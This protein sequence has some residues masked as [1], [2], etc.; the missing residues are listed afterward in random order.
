MKPSIGYM[1][2]NKYLFLIEGILDLEDWQ[3]T[4]VTGTVQEEQPDTST[5]RYSHHSTYTEHQPSRYTVLYTQQSIGSFRL[6]LRGA[7]A[8]HLHGLTRVPLFLVLY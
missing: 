3:I 6:T 8:E 5:K 2:D 4:L 1:L 7:T